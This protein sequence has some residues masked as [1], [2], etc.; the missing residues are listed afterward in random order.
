M[1]ATLIGLFKS[2]TFWFNALTGAAELLNLFSSVMPSGTA[3]VLSAI[4]N[5]GLRIVTDKP[6]SEK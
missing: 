6:L 4:V 2:K 1:E 3:L 5:I